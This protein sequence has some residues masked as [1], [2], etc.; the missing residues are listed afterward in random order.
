MSLKA[1]V[2]VEARVLMKIGELSK[3]TGI[4]VTTIR[5]FEEKNLLPKIARTISNQRIYDEQCVERLLF[6]KAARNSGM[7]LSCIG[8][9]LDY[10]RDKN[11]AQDDLE[12]R[13]LK[14]LYECQ[15][16]KAQMAMLE[17]RLN[18]VLA[19]IRSKKSGEK[20][21]QK[22]SEVIDTFCK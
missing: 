4:S 19:R 14:I 10:E 11:V 9:I 16:R 12:E 20:T 2:T 15:K 17:E 3:L 1:T 5:F 18:L 22:I 21:G 7:K 8:R 6:I 13:I